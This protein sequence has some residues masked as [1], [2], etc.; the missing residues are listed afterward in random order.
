MDKPIAA[1]LCELRNYPTITARQLLHHTG[2]LP[3]YITFAEEYADPEKPVTNQTVLDIFRDDTPDVDFIPGERFAYSN[4]GYLL[5]ASLVE[6]VSGQSF[7]EFLAKHIFQPLGMTRSSV[8]RRRY[9]PHTISDYAY[10]FIPGDTSALP[11]SLDGF[12]YVT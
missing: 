7:G 5:L 12:E 6:R 4:T 2:G 1:Y 9:A 10:G 8:Y 3:D 11:D